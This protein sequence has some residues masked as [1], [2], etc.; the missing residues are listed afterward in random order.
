MAH[1]FGSGRVYD[2][3]RGCRRIS[4]SHSAASR[5]VD[6]LVQGGYLNRTENPEDRRQKQLALT[7]QGSFLM[8][9][10]ERKFTRG[11]EILAAR[12]S[13]EEQEQFRLLIAQMVVLQFAEV[14]AE[15]E[16]PIVE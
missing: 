7:D 1:T 2:H 5:V 8:K 13:V 6:R 14:D 16:H 3:C 12:L 4:I 15:L 11:I 9:D 10:I